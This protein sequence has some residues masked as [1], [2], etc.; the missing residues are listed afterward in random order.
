M[1]HEA[2]DMRTLTLDSE[3][4]MSL[5]AVLHCIEST[6]WSVYVVCCLSIYHILSVKFSC[7]FNCFRSCDSAVGGSLLC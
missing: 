4:I 5:T 3:L 7:L 6:P 2:C 1:K